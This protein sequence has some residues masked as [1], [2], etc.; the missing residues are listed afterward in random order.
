M[1]AGHERGAFRALTPPATL[2]R[3]TWAV[4][5]RWLV[6]G[7]FFLLALFAHGFGLLASIAPC[8]GAAVVGAAMNGLNHWCVHRRRHVALV[9]AIAIPCDHVLITYVVINTGGVQS[10]LMMMYVVQVLATAMLVDTRV[11]ALS[12]LFAILTW[13]AGIS[14]RSAGYLTAPPLSLGDQSASTTV[15]HGM[16]AAFLFY[17][18][19]LLVYLGGYISERL[20]SSERDLAEKNR[21][22]EEALGSLRA[23]HHDLSA[24]YDRLKQTEAHLV[25]SEKM[26]S[27]GQLVAGVAHELSNPISFISANVEHLRTYVN[28][29][30]Q[31]LDAYASMPLPPEERTRLEA[32][33]RELRVERALAE[34]PGLLD[35]CQEGARRTKHIVNELR[36]FSRSDR[37]E[38]WELVDL[39]RNIDSTLAL[40]AHR[41]KEHVTVHRDYG[42][43][44]GV[45]CLAGPLNKVLMNLLANAAD[46]IGPR[47]GN[48]WISTRVSADASATDEPQ[49]AIAIRDD[50]VGMSPEL[51]A[52]IFDPLFTT[53]PVGQGTGLGLSVSY[54]IVERHG[55]TLRVEST[56][57]RGSTFTLTLPVRQSQAG[58]PPGG[59]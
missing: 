51:R 36:T 50:G 13:S 9:T 56:P 29:L 20:Q 26:R 15:Y 28:A 31:A 44:P 14:V 40:L 38:A 37:R 48:V 41:L 52:K 55:G 30:S 6:I 10:P 58:P 18:L 23:A 49:V 25:Q 32:R 42:E 8:V 11:A 22:L 12:A 34:L 19:A 43:L 35:D 39:H 7:G 59:R 47:N 16:W 54:G 17:C 45:E 21:R 46:A 3:F 27:L 57:G 1:H 33:R 2:G 4:R 53:K 5:V 24:A